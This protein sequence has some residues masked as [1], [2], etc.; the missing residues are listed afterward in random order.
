M[1]RQCAFLHEQCSIVIGK[2]SRIDELM[3][4]CG[5][6]PW[7]HNGAHS[8]RSDLGN[9]ARPCPTHNNICCRVHA[10]HVSGICQ[11]QIGKVSIV[12]LHV[13]GKLN[14]VHVPFACN[15][16]DTCVLTAVKAL[17]EIFGCSIEYR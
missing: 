5:V 3:I 9:R 15:V 1:M 8:H 2:P 16:D 4:L 10:N 12:V 13:L 7:N 11:P 17:H 6:L 14:L